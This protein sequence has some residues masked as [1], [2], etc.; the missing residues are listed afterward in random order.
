MGIY[1]G[2]RTQQG[3]FD[4]EE[5]DMSPISITQRRP[6]DNPQ[7]RAG[8]TLEF[9]WKAIWCCSECDRDV[10]EHFAEYPTLSEIEN[11]QNDPICV[12]CRQKMEPAP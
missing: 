4:Y 8:V 10:A 6:G 1:C 3:D 7:T 12:Y 5:P 11:I 9:E 2:Y